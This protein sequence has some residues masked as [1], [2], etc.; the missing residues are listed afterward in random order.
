LSSEEQLEHTSV[1]SG[2]GADDTL[3]SDSR[4]PV[5]SATALARRMKYTTAKPHRAV[6][7]I[8]GRIIMATKRKQ[9]TMAKVGAAVKQAAQK[10]VAT[11]DEYVAEPVS[12]AL[13]LKT[14]KKPAK[15]ST[16][17]KP[18]TAKAS[19]RTTTTK[20]APTKKSAAKQP[21][22]KK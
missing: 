18:A 4:F 16:G 6:A 20:K 13:G 9:G 11:A 14:K 8:Q 3:A 7:D 1:L 12:K 19:A 5:I 15:R 10:V 21:A 17:K 22:R 2:A